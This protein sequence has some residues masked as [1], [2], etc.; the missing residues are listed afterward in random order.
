MDDAINS[1]GGIRP[2]LASPTFRRAFSF[3]LLLHG[4]VFGLGL[5][6]VSYWPV[7][8]SLP[9]PAGLVLDVAEPLSSDVAQEECSGLDR[10]L[11]VMPHE[12]REMPVPKVPEIA[13]AALPSPPVMTPEPLPLATPL[14]PVAGGVVG[15]ERR[16]DVTA[17]G[18]GPAPEA[19]PEGY[20]TADKGGAGTR[21]RPMALSEIRPHYPYGARA[22]GEAGRVT[23]T[24][25]VDDKGA[26]EAVEITASSGYA[27]L[28][29]S[30]M[31]STKKARFRPAE[32]HGHPVPSVMNLQFEFRLEER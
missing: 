26:V 18:S 21:G 3:A 8:R 23:V 1:S 12:S 24:V 19:A 27:A 32:V 30:A 11:A 29:N 16:P 5:L 6:F 25:R 20:K 2:T 28:D 9:V 31:A 22:R 10:A 13:P 14:R 17:R 15:I 7:C 4:L